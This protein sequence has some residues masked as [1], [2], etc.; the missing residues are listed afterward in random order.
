VAPFTTSFVT[1]AGNTITWSLPI[2]F[3]PTL[4]SRR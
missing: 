2:P 3:D 1:G 4:R